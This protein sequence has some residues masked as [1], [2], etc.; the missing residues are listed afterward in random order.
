MFFLTLL[1]WITICV[2]STSIRCIL[3]GVVSSLALFC[4][5][6]F[7]LYLPPLFFFLVYLHHCPPLDFP[8]SP[9]LPISSS[10]TPPSSPSSTSLEEEEEGAADGAKKEEKKRKKGRKGGGDEGEG[11]EGKGKRTRKGKGKGK[12]GGGKGKGGKG[13]SAGAG[14]EEEKKK[15][16]VMDR[17]KR[18]GGYILKNWGGVVGA[19]GGSFFITCALIILF[20]TALYHFWFG[21]KVSDDCLT[22]NSVFLFSRARFPD[23]C[24]LTSSLS[25]FFFFFFF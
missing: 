10:E 14:G 5:F 7:S 15:R 23:Y 18:V 4:R 11:E 2:S 20:D 12:A 24:S 17:A 3:F 19:V 25:F 13:G 9:A 1:L 21:D 16:G 6:T 22:D 8:S